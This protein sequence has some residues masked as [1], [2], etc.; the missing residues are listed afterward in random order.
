MI[1]E[2]ADTL[3]VALLSPLSASA[4]QALAAGVIWCEP[5]NGQVV[6]HHDS[7]PATDRRFGMVVVG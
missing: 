5:Q 3:S 7:D 2:F 6:V 1:V 4:A